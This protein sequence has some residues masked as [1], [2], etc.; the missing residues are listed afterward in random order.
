MADEK[1]VQ[2]A[3]NTI[4]TLSIDA[5]Q[6]AKSGHPGHADG[7][8]AAGLHDLEQDHAVRSP[9]PDL[10][11]PRSLR[12]L[13][14]SCLDAALV[15][16]PSDPH[17][18]RECGL[19]EP[20]PSF[21]HPRR[22][23]PLPPTRQQGAWTSRSI[24]GFREWR[25]PP[26]P[27]G[28]ASPRAWA[29]RI[30]EKWLANRYNRSGFQIF[31]Y[32]IYAICGDGCLMEGVASEAASLAAHLELGQPLLDLR[33]QPHHHRG[34]YDESPLRKTSRR[35]SWPTAGTSCASAMPTT[36]SASSTPSTFS[37]RPRNAPPSSFWTATSAT[38]RRTSR[39]PRRPT[40]SRSA[41]TRSG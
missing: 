29:W 19:R 4:R 9:G 1:M 28:K 27:S 5:V 33:Q 26:V 13:Q 37:A 41:T 6:Q 12:A 3:I 22:H 39:T 2:T 7:A 21:G 34:E 16:A 17:S 20:G 30:A 31:D 35:D 14:R 32:N 15:R 10:A 24:T 25:P 11:Q 40:A 8:R 23:P 38:A 36:S 18:G